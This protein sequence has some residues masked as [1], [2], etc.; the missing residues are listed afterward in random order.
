MKNKKIT[1]LLL[2]LIAL[3]TFVF[4]QNRN[5]W[6]QS[7]ANKVSQ[8]D[9][10]ESVTS[11]N[12]FEVYDLNLDI[13]QN[14][15]LQAPF[16]FQGVTSDVELTFPVGNSNYETFTIYKAQTMSDE[17][18]AK[19]PAISSYVGISKD[20]KNSL[21]LTSTSQGIFGSVSTE[22]GILYI[23]PYT[24]SGKEYQ[25]FFRKNTVNNLEFSCLFDEQIDEE[26]QASNSN[27]S[28][29][30]DVNDSTLRS[31]RIAV[32]ATGEYSA[33]HVG[34]TGNN[35]SSDAVKKQAVVEAIVA[36]VNRLNVIYERDAAVT[37]TLVD[38]EDI[39][40]LDGSSDPFDNNNTQVL[41][42]QSQ[43]V[44][45]ANVGLANYDIGH[46]FSTGAGGLAQ[47]YSVCSTQG[48]A[49]GV[50]GITAP[51][52]DAYAVDFVAH[53]VGHQFSAT[54]TF[55]SS[56]N[57]CVQNRTGSTAVEPGSGSTIMAYA[58]LCDGENVQF[59]SDPHFHAASIN[60]IYTN[61]SNLS[62]STCAEEISVDNAA[63]TITATPDYTIP[64][65]TAFEL[66]ASAT[67]PNGDNLTYCWEQMDTEIAVAPPSSQSTE[68]ASFRSISPMESPTRSFPNASK[69]NSGNLTPTWEVISNV[70]R[71]YN[72][73]VT[74]RDNNPVG[75][76]S[77]RDDMTVTVADSGP[78]KVTSQN[79]SGLSYDQN[80]AIEITWDVAGTTGNG[81]NTSQVDIYLSYNAGIDYDVLIASSR[82]N[83]GSAMVQMP[84]G[85]ASSLCKLKIKGRYNV[86]YAVNEGFFKITNELGTDSN[87][88][89]QLYSVYPNPNN[90]SFTI[91]FNEASGDKYSAKVYDLRGRLISKST[92]STSESL[93][94]N[95]NLNQPQ[96]G[97]YILK[98]SNG[99][100]ES[101]KKLIV[102]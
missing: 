79:T 69:V 85:Q 9:I 82:T 39:I 46:T 48:K 34:Q 26:A 29:L 102:E 74:V 10:R 7:D 19:Y 95:I 84:I 88:L 37:F 97:I 76:Q 20:K 83:D 42:N 70:A 32:A 40:F 96:S 100:Q 25:V 92:I 16:R 72:F 11:V 17:M 91:N 14:E 78:F 23:N 2:I 94:K 77:K 27:T 71:E 64:Y 50:T 61:I 38:N 57:G 89:S 67:D 47:L 63:P 5:F 43:T 56:A 60:Q 80:E 54:H 101:V 33:Y 90:G 93:I 65:G 86:F 49:R 6:T 98:V 41:I 52:G 53:E 58:G 75:G 15:I 22:N 51:I 55:N 24:L 44:I 66:T 87:E 4:A 31:Y 73:A 18:A 59:S 1:N 8:N 62:G 30:S 28:N 12:K 13:F 3:P 35:S 21:R 99:S 81:I 45:D 36:V 68:G